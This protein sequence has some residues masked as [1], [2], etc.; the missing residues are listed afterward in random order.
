MD[1]TAVYR[2]MLT[3][4]LP[5]PTDGLDQRMLTALSSACF[6]GTDY[7]ASGIKEDIDV[8]C[9]VLNAQNDMDNGKMQRSESDIIPGA[10]RYD[11]GGSLGAFDVRIFPGSD[12]FV[13]MHADSQVLLEV[14]LFYSYPQIDGRLALVVLTVPPPL[15]KYSSIGDKIDLTWSSLNGSW[16]RLSDS[17]GAMKDPFEDDAEPNMDGNEYQRHV[18]GERFIVAGFHTLLY[19]S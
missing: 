7:Y 13:V 17:I 3:H 2:S 6:Y 14:S 8:T 19:W 4:N 10:T 5:H 12:G 18:V 11:M 16:G 9:P 15:Q 1:Y